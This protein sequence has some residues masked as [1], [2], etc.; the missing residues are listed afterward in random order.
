MENCHDL[1]LIS[2]VLLLSEVFEKVRNNSLKNYGICPGHHL[3]TP[4]LN[5][6]TMIHMTKVEL[7]LIPDLDMYIFFAKATI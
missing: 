3:S 1:Y 2:D 7:K 4:A 5:W 6:D